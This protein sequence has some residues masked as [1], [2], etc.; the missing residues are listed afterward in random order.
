MELNYQYT[1]PVQRWIIQNIQSTI[2]LKIASLPLSPT[3][4]P[5]SSPHEILWYSIDH[6]LPFLSNQIACGKYILSYLYWIMYN[7]PIH[8]PSDS[9]ISRMEMYTIMHQ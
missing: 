7:S 2:L 8:F 1:S 5:G 4:R 3:L 6:V 9:S